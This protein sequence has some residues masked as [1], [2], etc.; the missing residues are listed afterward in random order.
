MTMW[1]VRMRAA[2]KIGNK[3]AE[4][5]I[6]GAETICERKDIDRTASGFIHRA[7]THPRG[8]P[9]RIIVTIEELH[10]PPLLIPML[11]VHT[12]GADSPEQALQIVFDTLLRLAVSRKAVINAMKVLTGKRQM[13][14]AAIID[15]SSGKRREPDRLRG[16]RVSRL[17]VDA[18][19]RPS[20]DRMLSRCGI[21]TETVREAL[22][23]A[24][25]V[26]AHPSIIAEVCMSDDPDY[27]TGY[28]ASK[29]FGY[30]RLPNIKTPGSHHGGRV[31]FIRPG[32][33]I[34]D[35]ISFLEQTPVLLTMSRK[36]L[37]KGA[38]ITA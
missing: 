6:S 24:S 19:A 1:N 15:A 17:G 9:D 20:L 22:T 8:R 11:P 37:T 33:D 2:R 18:N 36:N 4:V 5:H 23:L 28:V 35:I 7:I 26:A 25:K 10:E 30:I 13:R 31:F 32:A 38:G 21:N 14:G 29:S 16:I 27:K 3:K 34:L 12:A